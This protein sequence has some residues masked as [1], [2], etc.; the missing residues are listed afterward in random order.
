MIVTLTYIVIVRKQLLSRREVGDIGGGTNRQNT[1]AP[2]LAVKVSL[3]IGSQLASWLTFIGTAVYFQIVTDVPSSELFE[4]IALVVL[5]IN[6][7]LNPIFYSEL[8]KTIHKFILGSLIEFT[9][10]LLRKLRQESA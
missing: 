5:P 1:A 4:V 3:M 6:S 10:S 9:G 8:Y 2:S 7:V